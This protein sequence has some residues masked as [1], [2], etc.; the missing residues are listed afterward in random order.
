MFLTELKGA[1]HTGSITVL[2]QRQSAVIPTDFMQFSGT[3]F[4]LAVTQMHLFSAGLIGKQNCVMF[5]KLD[6][7]TDKRTGKL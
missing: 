7:N 5:T 6:T 1:N 2:L 3:Y 4:G